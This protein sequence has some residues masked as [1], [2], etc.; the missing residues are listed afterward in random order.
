MDI[1]RQVQ[2]GTCALRFAIRQDLLDHHDA[3]YLKTT[4][5]QRR[6]KQV[7]QEYRGWNEA[8]RRHTLG[9]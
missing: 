1:P 3:H 5:L 9:V 2:C 7:E 4:M 8:G 6:V